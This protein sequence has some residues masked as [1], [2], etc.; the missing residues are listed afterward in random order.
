[1]AFRVGDRVILRKTSQ[2]YEELDKGVPSDVKSLRIEDHD[3]SLN[4]VKR[5]FDS[6]TT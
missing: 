1:M 3:D 5:T 6:L 2:F 4:N